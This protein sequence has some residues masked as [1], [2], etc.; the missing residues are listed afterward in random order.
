ML[1]PTGAKTFKDAM[2]MGSEVYH[3]L[4]NLYDACVS[5][6]FNLH[7][8]F[9]LHSNRYHFVELKLNMALMQPMLV[10]KAVSPP[11]SKMPTKV[12]KYFK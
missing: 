8:V 9:V 6:D 4:K 7:S 3:H 11:I 5:N 10:M 1:L 2:R 12:I